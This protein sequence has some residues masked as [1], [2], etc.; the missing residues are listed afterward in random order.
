MARRRRWTRIHLSPLLAALALALSAGALRPAAA[1]AVAVDLELA[2]A[3]DVSGST[4]AAEFEL[5]IRGTAAA[6]RSQAVKDAID[7]GFR[8]QIAVT[9]YFWASAD[10]V[11]GLQQVKIPWTLVTAA[12]A[13]AFADAIEALLDPVSELQL[14]DPPFPPF[15]F[16]PPLRE[17]FF[18]RVDPP[19]SAQFFGGTGDGSGFTAVAQ[20]ID[21]GRALHLAENGFETPR[22]VLDVSGDGHENVDF[23]PAGC[24]TCTPGII[25]DPIV[26][27]GS[28]IV[29]RAT[30]FR[31]TRAAR[32]AAVAAD[33][34]V[35]GLP[36][37]TDIRDLDDHF[38]AEQVIGGEGSFL[39]VASG[40]EAFE[41]A[42]LEKATL[43]VV[44]EPSRALLW[45]VGAAVLVL[46][47]RLG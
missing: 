40:F 24:P 23:D 41:S 20:A 2:L 27:P 36:I 19:C 33:I 1:S 12:S 28:P 7:G 8:N 37:L 31:F 4:N 15:E 44:P 26:G 42:I 3:V 18:T 39:V 29:D 11:Q 43:E 47:R 34:V 22:H 21:F 45:I 35:N 13:D 10:E 30:Y 16:D 5:V 32:D 6:F 9:M 46:A 17:P 25:V 38:Y 14:C